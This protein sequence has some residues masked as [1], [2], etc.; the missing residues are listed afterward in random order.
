MFLHQR[1]VLVR[2]RMVDRLWNM[3]AEDLLQPPR[4][5]DT[6][7]LGM[8]G[9]PGE[10]G[11][12]FAVDFVQARLGVIHSDQRGWLESSDLAAQLAADRAGCPGH[13][14]DATFQ[15]RMRSCVR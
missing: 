13:Q 8:K 7:D 15:P 12:K 3:L 11:A 9:H 14:Y 5:L 10:T 6:S 4:I 2:C 1:H